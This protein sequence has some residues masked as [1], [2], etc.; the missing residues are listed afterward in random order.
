MKCSIITK[1][2]DIELHQSG[3]PIDG[4]SDVDEFEIEEILF[5]FRSGRIMVNGGLKNRSTASSINKQHWMSGSW[6]D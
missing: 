5:D 2:A 4:F 6:R 3:Q 1:T